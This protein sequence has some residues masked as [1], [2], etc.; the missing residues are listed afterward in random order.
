[1]ENLKDLSF[2]IAL[3]LVGALFML[4]GLSG[5]FSAANYSLMLQEMWP[6]VIVSLVGAILIGFGVYVEVKLKSPVVESTPK[7]SEEQ[8]GKPTGLQAEAFFFTLDSSRAE[9]FPDMVQDAVRVD[10]LGRTMV[11][12]LSQYAGAFEQLARSGS[13]IRLLL[14]DPMSE[15][16]KF[17]YGSSTEIYRSNIAATVSHLKR[18]RRVCGAQL[19]VKVIKHAPTSSIVVV[20]KPDLQQSFIQV[21]L[22]FLHGAVGWDRPVCRVS[23]GDKWYGVFQKEFN[24]LWSDGE[25]WNEA[26]QEVPGPGEQGSDEQD[27]RQ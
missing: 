26:R 19:Q 27:Q 14:V 15:A 24:Q 10:I 20:E 25:E 11:N 2:G 18:L 9:S 4:L 12:L 1:M 22:Y 17:L 6:R 7:D 16:C 5:G 21:Q 23:H 3:F 13:E 8:P